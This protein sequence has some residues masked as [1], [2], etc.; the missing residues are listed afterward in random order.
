MKIDK[1]ETHDRWQHLMK[2][3]SVNI[4][5][6]AEDCLKRNSLSIALQERSPYIYLYAHPRTH[7]NGYN[8]RMIWQPRLSKPKAEPNSYLFRAIS[9]T[10]IIEICWLL[11]PIELWPQYRKGNITEHELVIWSIEQYYHNRKQLEAA[12]PDDLSD[13]VGAAIYEKIRAEMR[14]DEL[15]EKLFMPKSSEVYSTPLLWTP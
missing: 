10:D 13:E 14:H 3:Q 5:Q 4:A 7:E 2:D 1:L 8:Q 12:A 9:K 15:R 6:G 11:P